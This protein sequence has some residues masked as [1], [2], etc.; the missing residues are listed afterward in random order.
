M[1]ATETAA[2]RRFDLLTL[3]KR[4]LRSP[5]TTLALIGLGILCGMYAPDVAHALSPIAN[6]YLNLLKMVVLPFLISAVI[7]SITSMVQDPQ[8]VRYL[9]RIALAVLVVSVLGVALSGTLSLILQPGEISDPQ[10]RIELGQFIN[11]QGAVST[12]LQLPLTPPANV[13]ET[14]GPVSIILGLVP[15]NV[16]GS[17]AK[18]DAIQVLLFCLLFGLAVG[19]VPQQSSMSLARVLDAVYRACIILT[20]WFIWALPFATFILI[21]QQTATMGPDP[22]KLMGGFLLVMGLS[23]LAVMLVAF[24][25]VAMRSRQGYWTTVKAFQPLLMVIITTRSSVAALPWVINL[26]VERLRFNQVVVELLAPLN[27]AL[28]RT[29]AIFLYVSGVIFIAQLYGRTLSLGDLALIGVSSSLLALTTT[30]MAGL[31]ILSQMSIL[32]GYLKLPFEAAFVLFVAVD[33]VSDTFMTLSS[34]CTV[35]A[36]TAAIAPHTREV[37]DT[38]ADEVAMEEPTGAEQPA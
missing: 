1:P 11:S 22:L 17:L 14:V 31:V 15:S 34:V 12:D 30:G 5:F 7:F 38:H 26:L 27:V 10:S 21:A 2:G 9:P 13:E 16:F 25:I 19:Q 35:T 4:V 3:V 36:T 20:N 28:L 8:S 18:G 6:A 33:A 29:G 32:C 24:G 37:P 23:T